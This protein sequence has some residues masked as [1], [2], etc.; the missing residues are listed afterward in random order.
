VITSLA[1]LAVIIVLLSACSQEHE[2]PPS[3]VLV[4]PE[5]AELANDA[6]RAASEVK[7]SGDIDAV[8]REHP[9]SPRY[10]AVMGEHFELM[11]ELH[12]VG[13]DAR[14]RYPRYSVTIRHD[15]FCQ[16]ARTAKL[17]VTA[18]V[19]YDMESI[20]PVSGAPPYTASQEEHV[21]GFERRG[22]TEWVMAAHH[23]ITLE[24]MHRKDVLTRLRNPCR[25]SSAT[26]EGHGVAVRPRPA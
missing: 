22:G 1:R 16:D 15:Q 7:V 5:I 21:F 17:V 12:R 14:I 9:L 11:R 2:P 4:P 26:I 6:L 18:R 10:S 8:L 3:P 19:R 25:S 13:L 20:P 23:E 24:E